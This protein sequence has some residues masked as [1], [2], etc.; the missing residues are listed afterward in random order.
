M[1]PLLK[2]WL[3]TAP[4]QWSQRLSLTG[5]QPGSRYNS[6]DGN[7]QDFTHELDALSQRAAMLAEYIEARRGLDGCG[8]KDHADAVILCNK[9]LRA[10]RKALGY[11][12][13]QS[14]EF[15]F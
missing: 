11:S 14:G 6:G 5:W 2:K 9:R 15:N 12:Y 13:P 10:V 7:W 3:E 1:N 4:A 8:E